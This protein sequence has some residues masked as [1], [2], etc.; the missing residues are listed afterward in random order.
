MISMLGV[1]Y[2]KTA[3]HF[4]EALDKDVSNNILEKKPA[5]YMF[6]SPEIEIQVFGL[7]SFVQG[8][9]VLLQSSPLLHAHKKSRQ[10]GGSMGR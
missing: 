4:A 3:L 1:Q 9:A 10:K 8:I 5:W 2:G 7:L 6:S